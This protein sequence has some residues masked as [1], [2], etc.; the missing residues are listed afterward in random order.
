MLRYVSLTPGTP[1]IDMILH[2][3][4]EWYDDNS[5]M[6][7]GTVCDESCCRPPCKV[8]RIRGDPSGAAVECRDRELFN[9]QSIHL[10]SIQR[11]IR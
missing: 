1:A 9:C 2:S 3:C 10:I 11:G 8:P 7:N 4:T 5:Y 6:Y